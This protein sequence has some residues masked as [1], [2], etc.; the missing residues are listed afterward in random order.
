MDGIESLYGSFDN[1]ASAEVVSKRS[2]L[3]P[4][5]NVLT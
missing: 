4:C 5:A 2:R 1:E 3:S